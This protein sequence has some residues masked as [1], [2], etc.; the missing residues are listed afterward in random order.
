[1]VAPGRPGENGIGDAQRLDG[2]AVGCERAQLDIRLA[3]IEDGDRSRS[4]AT[5]VHRIHV[6]FSLPARRR[7]LLKSGRIA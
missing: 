5:I 4:A 6:L 2:R 1:M 7:N 3:D